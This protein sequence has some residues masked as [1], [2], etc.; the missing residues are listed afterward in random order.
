[1]IAGY[2]RRVERFAF[3]L[4]AIRRPQHAKVIANMQNACSVECRKECQVFQNFSTA[5]EM[6]IQW[7]QSGLRFSAGSV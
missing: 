7:P 6:T 2:R 1:V 4:Q 3:V 5:L